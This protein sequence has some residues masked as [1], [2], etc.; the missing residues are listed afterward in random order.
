MPHLPGPSALR[1]LTV[2]AA[3]VVVGVTAGLLAAAQLSGDRSP[4]AP[5]LRD[6]TRSPQATSDPVTAPAGW[7]EA[8]TA[9]RTEVEVAQDALAATADRVPEQVV[10]DR[11]AGALAAVRSALDAEP[12]PDALTALA[13]AVDTLAAA[14]TD[15]RQAHRIW[16]VDNPDRA[17]PPPDPH[18]TA[19]TGPGPDCGGPDSYE[20][21]VEGDP[22]FFTSTPAATGDGSNGRIPRSQLQPLPWCADGL[23]NRQWLVPEATEALIA[24]NA[25]FR[26]VFGENIA[27]DLSYRSY[28]DQV[29]MREVYGSLAARPGTSNHGLGTAFDTWEWEAYAFGSARYVWLVE[30]GPAHGWVAPAWAREDGSNPEYWHFEFQGRPTDQG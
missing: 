20:P 7:A 22:V 16:A 18:T 1:R 19:A 12:S 2:G 4:A 25:E 6:V 3:L 14:V 26:A 13:D 10:R 24:L 11:L 29:A 21:P 9:A 17:P 27:V 15:V 28:A 23:G 8:V 30:H 5:A